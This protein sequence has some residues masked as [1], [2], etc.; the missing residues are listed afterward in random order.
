MY[1]YEHLVP[2]LSEAFKERDWDSVALK[3]LLRKMMH[4]AQCHLLRIFRHIVFNTYLR[5]V[6][7]DG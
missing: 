2:K 4:Q 3:Q 1:F 7:E 5:P 6:I